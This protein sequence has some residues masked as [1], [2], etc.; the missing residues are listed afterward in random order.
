[1][2]YY[3]HAVLGATLALAA[4]TRRRHG[5]ALVVTAAVAA[6]TPDWDALS[7][8]YGPQAYGKVHRVWGHNLLVVALIGALVGAVAR[9]IVT[10]V[11]QGR[12]ARQACLLRDNDSDSGALTTA[13][14][15]AWVTVGALAALSH[16]P[17]DLIYAGRQRQADWPVALLWPFSE[18]GWAVPLMPWSDWGVT[19][20]L[21]V[22]LVA[23]CCWPARARATAVLTLLAVL[24][25]VTVR[26]LVG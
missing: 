23:L 20:L 21:G 7:K 19:V 13:G 17:F 8:W 5:W 2:M 15:A 10:S 3:D 12:A 11:Q 18:Q 16:L 4:G 26:N 6:M 1:M 14:L 24:G 22:E 25:Y 9:L